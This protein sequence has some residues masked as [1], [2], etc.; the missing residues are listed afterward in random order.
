MT[1]SRRLFLGATAAVATLS[2]SSPVLAQ[3]LPREVI[4][5]GGVIGELH[6]LADAKRQTTVVML[7]GS[8]GGTPSRRDAADLASA[9]YTVLALAYFQDW[10]GRP[11]DLP[12]ALQEIPLEYIF[13]ALGWLKRRPE[14]DPGKIVIMGQS[15][16]AELALLTASLRPDVAGVIGFSP[17]SWVWHAVGTPGSPAWTLEGRAVPYRNSA[18]DPAR[19]AYD[20][21]AL[22]QPADDARIRVEDIQGPIMLASSKADKIWPAAAYADEIVAARRARGLPVSNLQFDDAS[23]LLMGTGPGIVSFQVP[24]TNETFDFGGTVAGTSQARRIAWIAAKRFLS[25]I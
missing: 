11:D 18:V 19:S 5:E 25:A 4:R 7:N 12:G 20:W 6:Y 24:G 2:I 23:H 16:G 15:R 21:F 3:S 17:S 13:N 8:D 1:F 9:G 22:A 10:Q 14:V